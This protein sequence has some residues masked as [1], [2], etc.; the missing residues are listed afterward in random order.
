MAFPRY[1]KITMSL[2]TLMLGL[3][4]NDV[5]GQGCEQ[6]FFPLNTSD[7]DTSV[8]INWFD[9]N[10]DVMGWEIE[11]GPRGF[12]R[13]FMSTTPLIEV[14]EYDYSGLIPA[15]DY[16][17]YL[18]SVCALG[19]SEWNG[20]FFARTHI[21]NPSACPINILL[22]DNTCPIGELVEIDI[23]NYPELDLGDDIFLESVD[24]IIEHNWPPDLYIELL[25]PA[26]KS[27]VL[28]SYNG[29]GSQNYGDPTDPSCISTL[30][31]SEDACLL[32]SE[33]S[34]PFIGTFRSEGNFN[35][36]FDASSANG[37][38]ALS[39]CDR[40]NDDIGTIKHVA[41]NFNT[42]T[43][44]LP[45]NIRIKD[46]ASDQAVM[47]WES[48]SNCQI[49]QID[50][51]P[52]GFIPETNSSIFAGCTPGNFLIT[53]LNP[54]TT[55]DA[56]LRTNCPNSNSAFTCPITFTT[57]CK[58]IILA[59]SFDDL[60]V[61]N[62]NCNELCDISSFWYND[63]S[64]D[65]D[66]LVN[67]GPTPSEFT[68]PNGDA[69]DSGNYI[70]I[71]NSGSSCPEGSIAIL[72]SSCFLLENTSGCDFSFNYHM[73]GEGI[74]YLHLDI[75]L[76]SGDN[77]TTLFE[78]NSDQGEGWKEEIM[79][80]SSYEGRRA[81]FRF[82]AAS[83]GTSQGDIAIDQINFYSVSTQ[84]V[85]QRYYSDN[86]E[87]GYGDQS[88]SLLTCSDNAPQG[89]VN[90]ALDCNDNDD[91]IN[92]D[93]I[94]IPC[95]LVDENCNGPDDD[96]DQSNP[97]GISLVS[98]I[99][100][101][102]RGSGDGS[103]HLSVTGGTLPYS[104]AWNIMTGDSL[105][106]NLNKGIYYCD[107]VDNNGCLARTDFIEIK[108]EA[109]V[110]IFPSAIIEPSCIG[111][112]LGSIAISVAGGN[113]PYSFLW[114]NGSMMEDLS[115]VGVGTYQV[116]V[117]D[118]MNCSVISEEFELTA[119]E[120][121]AGVLV[122]SNISCHGSNDGSITVIANSGFPP[123]SFDWNNNG[124]GP[125]LDN[126][127]PG[128]YSCTIADSRGCSAILDNLKIIEPEP[129]SALIDNIGSINCNGEQSGNIEI[130]A[131]GGTPP[132][133]Y[134]WSNASFTDDIF[135]LQ[136]GI[137]SVVISDIN[138]CSFELSNIEVPQNDL[139]SMTVSSIEHVACPFSN[140]G[141]ITLN[142][143]GG[144]GNYFYFWSNGVTETSTL[145]GLT[146]D[147]YGVTLVDGLNCKV[148]LQGIHVG[149]L[150]LP[151]IL[152]TNVESINNCPGDR[153]GTISSTLSSG[154]QP[155][156][157]NWS[158]G[159]QHISEDVRDTVREL[160]SGAYHLTVTDS[161]GCIGLAEDIVIPQPPLFQ[162]TVDSIHNNICHDRNDGSIF[163]TIDG[164]QEPITYHWSNEDE[165]PDIHDLKN[166]L[167]VCTISD[168]KG[169]ELI[170]Q[171][172]NV[173]SPSPISSQATINNDINGQGLGSITVVATGGTPD[174]TFDWIQSGQS[175][176][177]ISS[178]VNDV[179]YIIIRDSQGCMLDTFFYVDNITNT[180]E[181]EDLIIQL[182]PNPTRD[183]LII[184]H[185][186][187][188]PLYF[189]IVDLQ[190]QIVVGK[191]QYESEVPMMIDVSKLMVGLYI[192]K[193]ESEGKHKNLLFFK[194]DH[195]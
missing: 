43:C 71:E 57:R 2:L 149:N 143:E 50:F 123:Y 119:S 189:S 163:L 14:T 81:L 31:F 52:T 37:T 99:D 42:E 63:S 131:Q 122:I 30:K 185:D 12:A 88:V 108:S 97:I 78:K 11:L 20:P 93:A 69:S 51:G 79:D 101:S 183:H 83:S 29:I 146:A 132:Y 118:I 138:A 152:N 28:S 142:V 107:V 104:F 140:D 47:T 192:F 98:V 26:G 193:I 68:G 125:T 195:D 179:Y 177:M 77:W 41:L 164:G 10:T 120:I 86:D 114:S 55:Y 147:T 153:T 91:V 4:A 1:I 38:W 73:H 148:T 9:A 18:R 109:S 54:G 117:Q 35:T 184:N 70:Y 17:Y 40:A 72:R 22:G 23:R 113:P 84:N 44:P 65:H 134:Q 67:S 154:E 180:S 166:G 173:T 82:I 48:P 160:A 19:N 87:D 128:I 53:G 182:Y 49:S 74:T 95:N 136:A 161:E 8:F 5:V 181:P 6:P 61:C 59:T 39:I 60:P 191:T 121:N 157:Y 171:A 94:E 66:W 186:T 194:D 170:T 92:P 167:Y 64:D 24:L 141:K 155:Y 129:L 144:D 168:G 130:S 85:G 105:L 62:T 151:L 115:N 15:T 175:G 124:S 56:Y 127:S 76:D 165:N 32:I 21:V 190:G 13:T 137:Y 45:F 159:Y 3:S 16:E 75:S 169:C 36:F 110:L 126:L 89:Y 133:S 116:T 90:N 178:L 188:S 80:L 135:N 158:S 187:N 102:C 111:D 103:I 139:L 96:N 106:D 176:S 46:I 27:I 7:T 156:D 172:L 33:A 34:P 145:Y 100:E 174:Y 58:K 25:S 162:L 112:T 150:N